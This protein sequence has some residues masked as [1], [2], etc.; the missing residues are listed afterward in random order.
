MAGSAPASMGRPRP[1]AMI[2]AWELAP[3]ETETTPAS[4][5]SASRMRS[6]GS[7][8]RPIRMKSPSG[9]GAAAAAV[10]GADPPAHG[11]GAASHRP[12]RAVDQGGVTGHEAADL[13]D[14]GLVGPVVGAE[15][16]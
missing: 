3:P 9:G 4:P 11:F 16:L 10:G 6:A 15:A 5:A 12:H 7:A 1:R 13:D 2:A 14:G 8:S